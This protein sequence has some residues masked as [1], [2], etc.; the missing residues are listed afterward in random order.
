M[1]QEITAEMAR[2]GNVQMAKAVVYGA[3]DQAFGPLQD[4][5]SRKVREYVTCSVHVGYDDQ[6]GTIVRFSATERQT[7]GWDRNVTP[8]LRSLAQH[9]F[10]TSH[11]IIGGE[12]VVPLEERT[13]LME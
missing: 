12:P 13:L 9:G 7:R 10:S 11:V 8:V 3:L 4:D 6:A 2:G 1:Y 5:E